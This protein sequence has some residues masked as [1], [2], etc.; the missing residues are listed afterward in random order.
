MEFKDRLAEARKSRGWTPETASFHA[1]ISPSYW[2]QLENGAKANPT[3]DTVIGIAKALDV[4]VTHLIPELA[5][6]ES[7]PTA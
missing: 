7:V 5:P 3:V 4:P 1:G 6:S 2:R